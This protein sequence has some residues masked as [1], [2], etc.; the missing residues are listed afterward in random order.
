MIG[1]THHILKGINM[2]NHICHMIKHIMVS[3]LSYKD[4]KKTKMLHVDVTK[5]I[6]YKIM[7]KVIDG[8]L[9]TL[10]IP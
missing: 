2:R 6:I 7:T 1:F 10:I 8:L 4:N 9:L 3:F 5:F